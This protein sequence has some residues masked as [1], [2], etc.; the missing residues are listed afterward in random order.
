MQ[1]GNVSMPVLAD[2]VALLSDHVIRLQ[3]AGTDGLRPRGQVYTVLLDDRS[4]DSAE[5]CQQERFVTTTDLSH[6]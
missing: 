3:I 5:S 6:A 1:L 2:D 4:R